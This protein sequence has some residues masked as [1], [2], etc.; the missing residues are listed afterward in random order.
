MLDAFE[1]LPFETEED[2][3]ARSEAEREANGRGG[4]IG[5]WGAG[6]MDGVAPK[7]GAPDFWRHQQS[8]AASVLMAPLAA[9]QASTLAMRRARHLGK[10]WNEALSRCTCME[11]LIDVNRAYGERAMSLG[12]G[13][14]WRF[15]ERA[16]VM[17]RATAAPETLKERNL[18]ERR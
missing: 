4:G 12:A 10:Q 2:A 13:E 16:S 7:V 6:P 17:G 14:M 15:V 8:M 3:I 9:A 11:E 5:V 18:V 1:K